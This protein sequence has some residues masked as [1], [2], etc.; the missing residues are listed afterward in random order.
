VKFIAPEL[1]RWPSRQ[2]LHQRRSLRSGLKEWRSHMSVWLTNTRGGCEY[3]KRR[4]KLNG[5]VE[6][7]IVESQK[8]KGACS[9]QGN[10]VMDSGSLK[11]CDYPDKMVRLDCNKCERSGRYRKQDLID[12][13]GAD[14]RLPDLR[15][16]IAQCTHRGIYD[17]CVCHFVDL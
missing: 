13:Y 17:A 2:N 7:R 1:P 5:T 10:R 16:Q 3:M 14:I 12:R 15:E 4:P 11:L 8:S 6:G 9:N